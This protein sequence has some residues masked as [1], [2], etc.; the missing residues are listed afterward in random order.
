M[1]SAQIAFG[2]LVGALLTSLFCFLLFIPL[3][4]VFSLIALMPGWMGSDIIL[5]RHSIPGLLIFNMVFYSLAGF[6]VAGLVSRRTSSTTLR[7][8]LLWSILPVVSL[9]CL[10]WF[11][12][13]NP[14]WPRGMDELARQEAELNMSLP[15]DT[16]VTRA[17]EVLA[18]EKIQFQEW[19]ETS[20]S[21][22][23]REGDTEVRAEI[24]DRILS[25]RYSTKAV[26]FPC[27]FDMEIYLVFG[28]Q[29]GRLK[30]RYVH[31]LSICP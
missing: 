10:T 17:R 5:G 13:T 14:L 20:N 26:M 8:L 9:F 30:S 15:L 24:G 28:G 27:G 22:L 21:V 31:R 6:V 19:V 29:D 7:R 23:M 25:S 1:N 12:S 3:V 16:D 11:P 18:N 4:N 2:F